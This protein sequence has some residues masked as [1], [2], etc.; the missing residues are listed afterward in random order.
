MLGQEKIVCYLLY[1]Q[2]KDSKG[3][4]DVYVRDVWGTVVECGVSILGGRGMFQFSGF[5]IDDELLWS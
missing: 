1:S 2:N 5:V 3:Q 4:M